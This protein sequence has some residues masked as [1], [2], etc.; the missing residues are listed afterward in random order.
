MAGIGFCKSGDFMHF[1]PLIRHNLLLV[2]K[3]FEYEGN[4]Y[5]YNLYYTWIQILL[6]IGSLL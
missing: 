1:L 6:Q 3:Q 4:S 2:Y 5:K